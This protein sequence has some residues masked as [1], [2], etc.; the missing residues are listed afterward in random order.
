MYNWLQVQ[1]SLEKVLLHP[2]TPVS[3]LKDGS[4]LV[5]AQCGSDSRALSKLCSVANRPVAASPHNRLNSCQGTI[6]SRKLLIMSPEYLVKKLRPQHVAKVYRF[7]V[8]GT[9]VDSPRLSLT[10][11]V[12]QL[13]SEIYARYVPLNVRQFVPR[14]RK[15]F[16]CQVYGH[17]AKNCRSTLSVCANCGEK[18]HSTSKSTPCTNT[19]NLFH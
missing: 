12:P 10:F 3:E 14:P 7:K 18:G 8:N 4:L 9:L 16:K 1:E 19:C 13:P 17:Q 11:D 15:C 5:K 2:R 6:F